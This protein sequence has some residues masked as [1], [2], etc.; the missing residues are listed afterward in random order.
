MMLRQRSAG[1]SARVVAMWPAEATR[2]P[3]VSGTILGR[4]VVPE[5][6]RTSAVSSGRA[7]LVTAGCLASPSTVRLNDPAGA[8]SAT[9]RRR[10]MAPRRRATATVGPVLVGSHDHRLGAEVTKVEVELV[11]LVGRVQGCARR[12]R[13]DGQKAGRHLR[14]VRQDDGDRVGATDAGLGQDAG[15]AAAQMTELCMGQRRAIGCEDGGPPGWRRARAARAA[16]S[17]SLTPLS[18]FPQ[19]ARGAIR[20]RWAQEGPRALDGA[21][22]SWKLVC[23]S[24]NR[25][26]REGGRRHAGEVDPWRY[27]W[28]R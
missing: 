3:W 8:P 7:R 6:W 26:D 13:G 2:L 22:R 15:G 18:A 20:G 24:S 11:L 23:R 27:S 1:P 9:S 10:T 4:E 5:V 19:A 14:P 17:P 28:V 25:P 21:P 16:S 12:G